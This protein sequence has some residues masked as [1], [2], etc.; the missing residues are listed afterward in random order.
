MLFAYVD[1]SERDDLFYFLGALICTA[2]QQI[3]LTD[4]LDAIVQKH[5]QTFQALDAHEE[6][7]GSSI[8]RAAERPW[9]SIP[10]RARFRI[11]EEALQAIESSGVRIYVEGVDIRRQ[12][13]RG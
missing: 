8:M 3:E 2:S 13:A 4:R 5:A 12:V 9:R 1:E 10:L 6:L 7:H 11:Y